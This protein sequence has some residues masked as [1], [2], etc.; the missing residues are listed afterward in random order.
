MKIEIPDSLRQRITDCLAQLDADLKSDAATRAEL[1]AKIAEYEAEQVQLTAEIST[2]KG[3]ILQDASAA[4][5][6]LLRQ[7][8]VEA[9]AAGAEELRGNLAGMEPVNLWT[10]RAIFRD[11]VNH[12]VEVFPEAFAD[13]VGDA[14]ANRQSA[15]SAA[16]LADALKILGPLR[17]QVEDVR[18]SDEHKLN[19]LRGVLK[20]ALTGR[21]YLGLNVHD[22]DFSQRTVS[23]P[24]RTELDAHRKL[25]FVGWRRF[26]RF[27]QPPPHARF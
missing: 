1:A 15:I 6:V 26:L 12:W 18:F 8:R 24:G 16:R 20:R 9:L 10:A 5:K 3:Q 19:V 7:L 27:V 14:F 11:V 13:C 22:H 21:P 2:L 4:E 17:N 25:L 23:L